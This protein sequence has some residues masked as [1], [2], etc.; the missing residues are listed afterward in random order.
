[1]N[2][3]AYKTII[4]KCWAD[5]EFKQRLM[6]DAVGTLRAEG[7]PVPEGTRVNVV[8]NSSRQ[9][10]FVIP[11]EPTE[12]SDEALDGVSGGKGLGWRPIEP[13]PFSG[14]P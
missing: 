1:M 4:T 2:E 14:R 9:F 12:L 13:N 11:S 10:T 5:P 8:E 3:Q 7:I 6:A